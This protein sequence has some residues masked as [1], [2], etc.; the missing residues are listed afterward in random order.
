MI[1]NKIVD[2]QTSFNH[3]KKT[4]IDTK[5]GKSKYIIHNKSNYT[6]SIID[7]ENDVY[8]NKENDTKCDFGLKT[9]ESFFYIELKGSDVVKG[10]K[11]L[12]VT[13]NETEKCFSD[14]NKKARL[15]VTRFS[16]PKIAKQTKEYKDLI[17]KIGSVEGF[18]I[19][20]NEYTEII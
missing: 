10:I 1:C 18:V 13:L 17:K 4:L 6:Y 16:K 9:T 12:L 3:P 7:F 2:C 20:Q 14:V 19:K 11:Q 5:G 8:K 15:I